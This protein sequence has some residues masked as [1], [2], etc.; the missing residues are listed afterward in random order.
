MARLSHLSQLAR[1]PVWSSYDDSLFFPY[2]TLHT[3]A[4]LSLKSTRLVLSH[5]YVKVSYHTPITHLIR[6]TQAKTVHVTWH[7]KPLS[8]DN[9]SS[10]L[11]SLHPVSDPWIHQA[12]ST[13]DCMCYS[14]SQN[15]SFSH[16]ACTGHPILNS[17][18]R[19]FPF[20][21]FFLFKCLSLECSYFKM[22]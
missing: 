4:G 1:L 19:F 16:T 9:H 2:F 10:P 18:R 11:C 6:G 12:L 21:F 15:I 5:S 22:L 3:A 13:Q 17:L 14:S 7:L 8:P 20:F